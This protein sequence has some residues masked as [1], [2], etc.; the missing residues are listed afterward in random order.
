LKKIEKQ[1]NVVNEE[2]EEK[3]LKQIEIKLN[4]EDG[5]M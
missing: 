5:L 2:Y 1:L 4:E 3:K